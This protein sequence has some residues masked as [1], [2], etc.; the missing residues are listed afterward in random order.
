ME[1]P[2]LVSGY[3]PA[4][5]FHISYLVVQQVLYWLHKLA[6][7]CTSNYMQFLFG[8]CFILLQAGLRRLPD[9][10]PDLSARRLSEFSLEDLSVA[11]PVSTVTT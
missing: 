3:G 1:P 6:H 4:S 11:N 9:A 10:G 2:R 5:P 7:Y 8:K